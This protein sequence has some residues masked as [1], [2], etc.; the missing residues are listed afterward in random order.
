MI[1]LNPVDF[2]NYL[3]CPRQIYFKYVM[4]IE[5]EPTEKMILGKIIHNV[6][7]ELEKRRGL[8]KYGVENYR[9]IF[10]FKVYSKKLGL[11]G[12]VDMIL[13]GDEE[14]LPVDFKMTEGN[15]DGYSLQLYAYSLLIK[16]SFN[17]K[18]DYGFIVFTSN[19]RIKRIDFDNDLKNL[20]FEVYD[21]IKKIILKEYFPAPFDKNCGD[22]E[23][24]NFCGDRE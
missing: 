2:K 24:I 20:F 10:D 11:S 4:Q 22:C 15:Y 7:G 13:E 6:M 23:Y 3:Y 1:V 19:K 16:E 21:D 12:S 14:V 8:S 18:S 17:K 9:K 5:S